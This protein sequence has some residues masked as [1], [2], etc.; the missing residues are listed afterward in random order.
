MARPE[1]YLAGYPKRSPPCSIV[2][3]AGRALWNVGW[4]SASAGAFS[5]TVLK[6]IATRGE[7]QERIRCEI[8]A[9]SREPPAAGGISA[10]ARREDEPQHPAASPRVRSRAK[11][12]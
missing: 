12:V 1:A 3:V 10:G 5:R 2:N 9:C 7:P 4:I 6:S 11:R 8:T